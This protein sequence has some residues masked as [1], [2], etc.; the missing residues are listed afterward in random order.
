MSKIIIIIASFFLL[1]N[2]CSRKVTDSETVGPQATSKVES[3]DTDPQKKY[4]E[5]C[6]SCH[7]AKMEMFVDRK[8][9]N[10]KTFEAIY[11]S[12]AQGIV[13]SGMPAYGGTMSESEL[14]ALT[15]YILEGVEDRASYESNS[16]ITP[17][18]YE[19][20]HYR[21]QIDT[22]VSDQ[23]VPWGM[24]V[25]EDGTIYF[26][27]RQ[28]TLKVYDPASKKIQE[29]KGV[30]EVRNAVQGG[31]MDVAFHPDHNENGWIY[32]S[33]SRMKKSGLSTESTTAVVRGKIQDGQWVSQEEIFE[34]QP[35]LDS[36]YHYGSR[37]VFDN[38][39]Y[40]YVTV[41]DR[42]KRDDHPQYLTNSCGKVH[43]IHDDGQIPDDNPFYNES[44]A[45]QSIW[46]YGHRN[47]QGLVYDPVTDRLW[48]NEHGP[49][50]GDEL[51]HIEK[52][53]NYGWPVVSYGINY[54]GTVF[55]EMTEKEGLESSHKVWIPSIA[56][57]GMAIIQGDKYPKWHG[58]IL[59]GSLRFNYISRVKVINDKLV[60]DERI[61]Q[62]IG[63][64]RC[65]EMGRDG[66][67]YV[68]VE[69]PGRILRVSLR[70]AD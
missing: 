63:R 49:R 55:T 37:L 58:D 27:E 18:Y 20:D 31:M 68:G 1:S 29:I 40:L 28:G 17:K 14:V 52:G 43:R 3:G 54:N 16:D 11:R 5:L 23:E 61:L 12:I 6:S 33:Y 57:S 2:S 66:Y 32:L 15:T 64:V 9:V 36:K 53:L 26:T 41:G 65:I 50:G 70:D 10:G 48:E 22:I 69:R 39:G 60:E 8:W 4:Q 56:P 59:T 7:G 19:S 44:D 51:N 46:S 67:L 24:K 21:L 30:P 13:S 47:P 38:A 62:D 42:G 45:I 34:A 35:F 25:L